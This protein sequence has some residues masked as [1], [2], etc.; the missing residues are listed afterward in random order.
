VISLEETTGMSNDREAPEAPPLVYVLLGA[1]LAALF[2]GESFDA[3]RHLI[4]SPV[5]WCGFLGSVIGRFIMRRRQ[6]AR[7]QSS[8]D[9]A[10]VRRRRTS[11][12]F[13]LSIFALLVLGSFLSRSV[14]AYVL[15]GY[16]L[17]LGL[18]VIGA[19]LLLRRWLIR[20]GR[21]GSIPP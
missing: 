2:V 5:A 3:G 14:P 11:F 10:A 18:Y 21:A 1:V 20:A 13:G 9:P 15:A 16:G 12:G 4:R 7:A 19:G 6:E 8:R 17:A